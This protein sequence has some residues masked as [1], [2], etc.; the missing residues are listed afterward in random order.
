MDNLPIINTETLASCY[1]QLDTV[2]FDCRF[3]L[4]DPAQG[5]RLYDEGHIPSAYYAN[6][7][8]DLSD[9]SQPHAGRHPL[10]DR[11]RFIGWLES[12][13]VNDTSMVVGYDHVGGAL[14]SRFWWL[15]RW[16]GIENARLLD[17]GFNAWSSAKYPLESTANKVNAMT[18]RGTITRTP[19]RI[20]TEEI[21]TIMD[22]AS[23]KSDLTILDA[24]E[25]ERYNGERE[26]IDPVAGHVPHAINAPFADNLN[27]DKTFRSEDELRMRFESILGSGF[28]PTRVIHMCG[29]GVTAC[30]NLIAME[31]AGLHGSR[32]YPGSFSQWVDDAAR[33]VE[34]KMTSVGDMEPGE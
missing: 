5:K 6:L 27:S 10:P 34:T 8:L 18:T 11:E 15:L 29:S 26:P 23:G 4:M 2:I 33:P 12:H 30:H 31:I 20:A 19:A 14:A 25:V 32:L 3:S 1:G 7:D 24:R 9:T 21:D 28:D 16:L 17:G 13:G 22:I